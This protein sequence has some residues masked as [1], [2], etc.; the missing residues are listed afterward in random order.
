MTVQPI[1][2]APIPASRYP[3]VTPAPPHGKAMLH[4][5]PFRHPLKSKKQKAKLNAHPFRHPL[6]PPVTEKQKQKAVCAAQLSSRLHTYA[7]VPKRKHPCVDHHLY[8]RET[9]YRQI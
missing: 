4:T 1:R 6:L 2:S 3:P 9:A 7:T 8:S 5:R